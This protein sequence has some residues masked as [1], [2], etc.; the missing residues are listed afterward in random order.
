MACVFKRRDVMK[1]RFLS[2]LILS[3]LWSSVVF[4]EPKQVEGTGIASG[5]GDS[6]REE[7][8]S[9]ALRN[10]LERSIGVMVSSESLVKN[11]QLI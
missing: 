5:S 2:L 9:K 7:A 11:F 1:L 6:A 10:A 3:L 8:V 4:S